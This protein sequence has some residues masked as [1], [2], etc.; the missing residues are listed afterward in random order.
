MT[1]ENQSK[2]KTLIIVRA[3]HN[4]GGSYL[5]D[6]YIMCRQGDAQNIHIDVHHH[7]VWEFLEEAF[8]KTMSVRLQYN[9]VDRFAQNMTGAIYDAHV[10][11]FMAERSAMT[12]N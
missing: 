11:E 9:C 6:R 2:V 10:I 7:Y 4:V 5:H 1:W 12:S 8:I 3:S